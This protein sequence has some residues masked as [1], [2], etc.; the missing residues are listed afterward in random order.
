MPSLYT[1]GNPD[2][3]IRDQ[4]PIHYFYAFFRVIIIFDPL[5]FE[6]KKTETP[7]TIVVAVLR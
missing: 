5:N 1:I 3:G 7:G 2:T 4:I 6:A